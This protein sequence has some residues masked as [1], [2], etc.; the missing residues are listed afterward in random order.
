MDIL[1]QQLAGL[2]VFL[3]NLREDEKRFI[4]VSGIEKQIASNQTDLAECEAALGRDKDLLSQKNREK[5]RIISLSVVKMNE[6]M[7]KILPFGH[8]F[9]NVDES[10]GLQFGWVIGNNLIPYHALSGGQAVLYNCA[11]SYAMLGDFGLGIL[12]AE[13]GEADDQYLLELMKKITDTNPSVQ[14]ILNTWHD[15]K[16]VPVGW[17]V[18][19]IGKE[20]PESEAEAWMKG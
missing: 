13:C 6:K 4:E 18:V 19:R 14:V 16:E 2:E 9:F 3:S 15:P 1:E 12:I 10:G 8:A 7:S 5:N 11:L 20:A 17:D